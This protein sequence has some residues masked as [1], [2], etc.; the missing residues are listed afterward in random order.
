MHS[1]FAQGCD[2][3]EIAMAKTDVFWLADYPDTSIDLWGIASEF[4]TS[5]GLKKSLAHIIP[6]MRSIICSG[7]SSYR[8][9]RAVLY[10]RSKQ[11]TQDDPRLTITIIDWLRDQG[12]L[13]TA[14][15]LWSQEN[16]D[17]NRTSCFRGTATLSKLFQGQKTGSRHYE[18]PEYLLEL[19]DASGHVLKGIRSMSNGK[20]KAVAA[21]NHLISR[22]RIEVCG[23]RVT[24]IQY[25]RVYNR[26]WNL[27]GRF[28]NPV[29][30]SRKDDRAQITIDGEGTVERD[31]QAL[32]IA[33]A[34]AIA[35]ATPPEGDPY[36]IPGFDRT[37]V[38]IASLVTLNGGSIAGVRKKLLDE[39][40]NAWA[41]RS[42]ELLDA[43]LQKHDAIC[44]LLGQDHIGLR[45]QNLDSEIAERV[46]LEMAARGVVTLGW[47][48]S[49][50][51][52]KSSDADLIITMQNAYTDI[53]GTP[54]PLVR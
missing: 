44:D 8:G 39:G 33:L 21:I 35:G 10:N 28:Y 45:L 41:K 9:S 32:H 14:K 7:L 43:F 47:H 38:K 27:G 54:S 2:F 34:Y 29:Q 5:C 3:Y 23:Q 18:P 36:K 1:S 6:K 30:T 52:K 19:R 22:A 4:K 13:V 11:G 17:R 46:M 37:A 51:V 20:A 24:G 16:P 25:H 50:L 49:F 15:G 26:T 53:T 42:G 12:L 40:M 31:F 48:D